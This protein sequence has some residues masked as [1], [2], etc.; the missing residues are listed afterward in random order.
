VFHRLYS[1][2]FIVVDIREL[3][4]IFFR[5]LK[6]SSLNSKFVQ[7]LVA[8]YVIVIICNKNYERC[9]YDALVTTCKL[10]DNV[11]RCSKV[12]LLDAVGFRF[13]LEM[14]N[15]NLSAFSFIHLSQKIMKSIKFKIP[16]ISTFFLK[17]GAINFAQKLCI[18]R[19]C[20]L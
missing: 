4:L 13:F 3:K 6:N 5:R 2:V 11:Q 8:I 10:P 9:F 16:L 20:F 19:Y 17:I 14:R 12:F 1:S 15:S 7:L 18:N